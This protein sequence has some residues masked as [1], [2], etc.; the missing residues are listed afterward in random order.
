MDREIFR[1]N[2]DGSAP[3]LLYTTAQNPKH[4]FVC[5]EHLYA[6]DLA[7]VYQINVNSPGSAT[8]KAFTSS[9][10]SLL[11]MCSANQVLAVV[12]VYDEVH[13]LSIGA[14]GTLTRIQTWYSGKINPKLYLNPS[15]TLLMVNSGSV[16]SPSDFTWL[17]G[18]TGTFDDLAYTADQYILLRGNTLYRYAANFFEQ[19]RYTLGQSAQR[20]VVYGSTIFAFLPLNNQ[21]TVQQIPLDLLQPAYPPAINPINLK[22][23]P[24]DIEH[25]GDIFFLLNNEKRNIHRWSVTETRYLESIVVQDVP[26]S[27]LYHPEHNRLYVVYPGGK[28]TWFDPANPQTENNFVNLPGSA[29]GLAVAGQYLVV[30]NTSTFFTNYNQLVY[31]LNGERVSAITSN[32]YYSA[33]GGLMRDYEWDPNHRRLYTVDNSRLFEQEVTAEGVIS[34]AKQ[35]NLSNVRYTRR[36]PDGQFVFVGSGSIYSSDLLTQVKT[37]AAYP[38]AIDDAVWNDAGLFTV[39]TFSNNN[40]RIQKWSDTYQVVKEEKLWGRPLRLSSTSR[41]LVSVTM[42]FG[43]PFFNIWNA[44]LK[45]IYP[46]LSF[47]SLPCVFN[48]LCSEYLETF[49]AHNPRW[50]TIEN[51]YVRARFYNGEYQLL[52]KRPVFNW[53]IK[54]PMFCTYKNYSISVNA[55]MVKPSGSV[56]LAFAYE[57]LGFLSSNFYTFVINPELSTYSVLSKGGWEVRDVNHSAIK[58][59]SAVNKLEV[60]INRGDWPTWGEF[61][62]NDILVYKTNLD[63]VSSSDVHG[64]YFIPKTSLSDARFDNYLYSNFPLPTG[65]TGS[66]F[67]QPGPPDQTML[68]EAM[69]PIEDMSIASGE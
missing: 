8:Q 65:V 46:P 57:D 40:Y 56:G 38:T 59:G 32:P 13:R 55:R 62:I 68:P 49:D 39:S 26:T 15:Q 44:D 16:F 53:F 35:I 10:A 22:Y 11:P 54:A 61:F 67:A 51:E 2:L 42:Q 25:G 21:I 5:G 18:F 29:C 23:E 64:I 3:L 36:S 7:S 58:T 37:I 9:Y 48:N 28:L 45:T 24:E 6:L 50:E 20:I 17:G 4:L 30:C 69:Q 33:S 34:A 52:A 60:R 27:I 12:G 47:V 14:D 1:Y 63:F 66:T 19:G 31:R 41:G 43:I